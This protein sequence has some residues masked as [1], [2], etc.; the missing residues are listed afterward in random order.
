MREEKPRG[1][2]GYVNNLTYS[3]YPSNPYELQWCDFCK[4]CA[5]K[6]EKYLVC[7]NSNFW[8]LLWNE[9]KRVNEF[10]NCIKWSSMYSSSLDFSKLKR[11]ILESTG[12]RFKN[13]RE[14][15]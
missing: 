7:L 3:D 2:D 5:L 9:P 15:R 6:D 8:D 10:G 14:S 4:F 1:E 11:K 12:I 13:E